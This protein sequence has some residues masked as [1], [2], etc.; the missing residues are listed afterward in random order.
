M[1]LDLGSSQAL[2]PG[3]TLYLELRASPLWFVE[4]PH[5]KKE[6]VVALDQLVEMN[7]WERECGGGRGDNIVV[8]K[9]KDLSR[10][11]VLQLHQVR[12]VQE[13]AHIHNEAF[14]LQLRGRTKK[15]GP[16]QCYIGV[17]HLLHHCHARPQKEDCWHDCWKN[18]WQDT[19][20]SRNSNN[21]VILHFH[22]NPFFHHEEHSSARPQMED[23][24]KDRGSQKENWDD[25]NNNS[26]RHPVILRAGNHCRAHPEKFQ[27]VE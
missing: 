13:E 17:L 19:N 24:G 2:T 9:M 23:Q 12:K 26:H 15:D 4:I 7:D 27:Q 1:V 5:F 6:A 20:N 3:W 22:P 8:N 14:P 10:P 18:H 16:H 11:E 21:R 25:N